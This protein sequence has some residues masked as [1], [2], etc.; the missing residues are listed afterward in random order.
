MTIRISRRE[1]FP[2]PLPSH[3]VCRDARGSE[4]KGG[5]LSLKAKT[6][7]NRGCSARACATFVRTG[8]VAK[9]LAGP[10]PGLAEKLG[11]EQGVRDRLLVKATTRS[12]GPTRE[13]EN[14]RQDARDVERGEVVAG[15]PTRASAWSTPA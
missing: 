8:Q 7:L 4:P 6:S 9:T 10:R 12:K 11:G 5:L 13:L 14:I 2:R 15:V 3:A 1:L